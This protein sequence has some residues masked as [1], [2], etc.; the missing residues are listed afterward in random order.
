MNYYIITEG[1]AGSTLLCDYLKQLGMGFPHAWLDNEETVTESI[2]TIKASIEEKRQN[3]ILGIKISWGI[4]FKIRKA[5]DDTEFN[6]KQFMDTLL[7][8]AKFIYLTRRNKVQQALSRIKHMRLG[9]SHVH[10]DEEKAEYEAKERELATQPV[11]TQEIYA[12]IYQHITESIAWDYFFEKHYI[13]PLRVDF[14]MLT[15]DRDETL[16]KICYFLGFPIT[17][18]T[19]SHVEATVKSTHTELNEEWYH[20]ILQQRYSHFE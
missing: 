17:E 20:T 13:N 12:R 14:E 19:L 5:F 9:A 16:M 3:G 18:L 1:R 7:P 8:N 4:L 11:P 2:E 15:R 10:S 6:V